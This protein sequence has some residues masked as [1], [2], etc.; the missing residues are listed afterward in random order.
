MKISKAAVN[1]ELARKGWTQTR[2]ANEANITRQQLNIILNRG[3]CNPIN[4]GRIASALNVDVLEI[5]KGD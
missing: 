1:L 2:L 4:A 5:T 3:T